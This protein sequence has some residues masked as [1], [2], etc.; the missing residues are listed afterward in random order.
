LTQYHK[1]GDSSTGQQNLGLAY[2]QL[3][4]NF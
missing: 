2:A 1:V 3:V 4:L